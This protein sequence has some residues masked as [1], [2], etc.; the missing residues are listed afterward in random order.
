MGA[1]A[2]HVWVR[3]TDRIGSLLRKVECLMAIFD[4]NVRPP[5]LACGLDVTMTTDFAVHSIEVARQSFEASR[6]S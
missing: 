6:P 5:R 2:R 1:T 3:L 4:R